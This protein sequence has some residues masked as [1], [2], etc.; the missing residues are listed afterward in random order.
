MKRAI[1]RSRALWSAGFVLAAL[2]IAG[3]GVVLVSQRQWRMRPTFLARADFATIG[4]INPGDRVRVQGMDAG[5]VERIEAPPAPGGLV[6]LW[7]RIDERLRPLVRS[8][9]TAQIASQ[10]VVGAK[11]IEIRPGRADAPALP[12]SGRIAAEA[13]PELSDLVRDATSVLKRVDA[14]AQAAEKGL[15]E[16]NAI[17]SSISSGKGSLGRLVQDEEAYRKLLALDDRAFYDRERV[18]FKPGS[19]RESKTLNPDQVFEP[20][21]SVLTPGGRILLDEIALW[22]KRAK[23]TKTEVVIAAFSDDRRDPD[24]TQMLTQEQADAVRTYLVNR[25]AIDAAGWFGT[26]KIASIGFGTQVPRTIADASDVIP[27]G[28]RVEII[29]FTPRT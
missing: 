8:D 10:G 12:E 28:R 18:L 29:L 2:A 22:F 5:V 6:T 9:A 24:L 19:D 21:R 11:V 27:P 26:R 17:A 14:V 20:G 23:K 13:T 25:H 1:S 7:F 15:I 16:V 4:G 3:T